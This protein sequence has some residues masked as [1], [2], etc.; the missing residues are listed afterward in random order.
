MDFSICIDAL[1][2]N[3]DFYEGMKE[4][5][6]LGYKAIEFWSWWDKD[7]NKLVKAKEELGLGI[8]TFCTKFISLNEEENRNSYIEALK[9]SIDICKSL[10]CRSLITQVG[11]EVL[12]ISREEQ[13]A[14]IIKGL[15][16][17]A[18]ILEEAGITLVVE[19]LNTKVDHKGYFLS[20]SKEAFHIIK[21]VGSPKVKVLYDIYHQQ[22][23]EGNII[24]TILENIDDIGHFHS[25]GNPG[26]H[27]LNTGEL[28]YTNIIKEIR[29]T[30]YK[31]Y[32][33]LEYFPLE[34]A[35]KGLIDILQ[36]EN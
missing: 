18:P 21:E 28:N 13:T 25:A 6:S 34:E 15:K 10:G 24:S 19:P 4:A 16:E 33:G 29:K 12:N 1:Y 27:E 36:E 2:N 31:G 14:S 23:M 11:N 35:K 30:S 32:F 20:S 17:A 3:K 5:K 22:I 7:I 8:A 9:E 26:R